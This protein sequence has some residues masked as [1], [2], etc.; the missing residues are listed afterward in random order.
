MRE[1]PDYLRPLP[2]PGDAAGAGAA[3]AAADSPPRR[4]GPRG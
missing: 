3:A 2:G 4:L 1:L